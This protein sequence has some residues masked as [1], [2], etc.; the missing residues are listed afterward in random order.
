MVQLLLPLGMA[1]LLSMPLVVHGQAPNE[2]VRTDAGVERPVDAA[3]VVTRAMALDLAMQANPEIAVAMREIEASEG[4]LRQAGIIPNPVLSAQ[5]EDTRY[6]DTR[7]TT[8]QISQPLELGGKRSARIAAAERARDLAMAELNAKRAEIRATVDAA[9]YSVLSAQER[10]RLAQ[11]SVEL[12]KR[13]TTIASRRVAAGKVS[14][15]DETRAR[16]AESGIRVELAQAESELANAR[17][18]LAA[19]WGARQVRFERVEGGINDLPVLPDWNELAT[20]L[21][22]S[23]NL[24]RARIEVARRQALTRVERS[25]QIPDVTV[26]VGA[27]RDEQLGRNQAIVGI[28]I[29]LPLFDR[30]QGN[31]QEAASRAYQAQD[32]LT[33]TV[34]RLES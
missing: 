8:V 23:P 6:R 3:G 27:M 1:A 31:V 34:V 16:V 30:N 32:Q 11:A 15:V 14:P 19:T 29:P 10:L 28:S 5:V 26:S 17:N 20:R 25:R 12:A 2:V 7:T 13:A 4:A 22:R 24:E 9:F 33:A 18:R 21:A